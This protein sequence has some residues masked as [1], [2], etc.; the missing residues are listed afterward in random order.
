MAYVTP[1]PRPAPA[2]V[3][4]RTGLSAVGTINTTPAGT[5][6]A[7]A[8]TPAPKAPVLPNTS[9]ERAARMTTSKPK[10]TVG[11]AA[12]APTTLTTGAAEGTPF[13]MMKKGGMV[14]KSKSNVTRGPYSK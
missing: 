11:T 2:P 10:A 5:T 12:P 4:P 9:P 14:R 8:A 13:R 6:K 7:V 3:A 1:R